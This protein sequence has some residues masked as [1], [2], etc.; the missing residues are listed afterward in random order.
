L[1]NVNDLLPFITR[2]QRSSGAPDEFLGSD[3]DPYFV[4]PGFI[5]ARGSLRNFR[6]LCIAIREAKDAIEGFNDVRWPSA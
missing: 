2:G 3:F 1:G 4:T 6:V 5:G